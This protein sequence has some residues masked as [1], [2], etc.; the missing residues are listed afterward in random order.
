MWLRNASSTNRG[1][2]LPTILFLFEKEIKR[3]LTFATNAKLRNNNVPS[4]CPASSGAVQQK[5]ATPTPAVPW[6]KS[7]RSMLGCDHCPLRSHEHFL[8]LRHLRLLLFPLCLNHHHRRQPNGETRTENPIY[9]NLDVVVDQLSW[10]RVSSLPMNSL[11][12]WV[13]IWQL[14]SVI[15]LHLR[16]ILDGEINASTKACIETKRYLIMLISK[17]NN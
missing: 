1:M 13:L 8:L 9:T 16:R 6:A 14:S 17:Y 15:R 10:K 12:L 3:R 7:Y 2:P 5:N 4:P 11:S